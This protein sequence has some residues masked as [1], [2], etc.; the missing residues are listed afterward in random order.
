M[1]DFLSLGLRNN[2]GFSGSSAGKESACNAE[3][4][5][6]WFLGWEDPL[7]KGYATHCS[8]LGL[9]I[10]GG[11]DGKES[12]AVQNIWVQSL[13]WEDPLEESMA[14]HSSILAWRMDREAWRATLHVVTKSQTRLSNKHKNQLALGFGFYHLTFQNPPFLYLEKHGHYP[15]LLPGR[16][17]G[18]HL[19]RYPEKNC[20]KDRT[21]WEL[22]NI[23][24]SV[25]K[26]LM[27]YLML[28][29]S[30]SDNGQ[31]WVDNQG[32][33]KFLVA[34]NRNLFWIT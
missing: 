34:R 8:I 1:P 25:Q 19:L 16:L 18:K 14:T 29:P 31:L 12:P 26:D 22:V 17:F 5:P 7:E 27:I 2:W 6:V 4:I 21:P 33:L 20:C 30:Q 24:I 23:L 13:D 32:S 9:S 10:L 11:S 28:L 15:A 3:E